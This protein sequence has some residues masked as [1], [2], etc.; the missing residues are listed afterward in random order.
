M[1]DDEDTNVLWLPLAEGEKKI[2]D[3]RR[4]LDGALK[5]QRKMLRVVFLCMALLAV[6]SVCTIAFCLGTVLR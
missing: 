4:Q 6:V 5:S 2:H 3:L 1:S